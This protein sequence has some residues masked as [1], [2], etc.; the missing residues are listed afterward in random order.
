MQYN[1]VINGNC[2]IMMRQM[3]DEGINVD[4]ILTDPP[5]NLNKDFG[6]DSDRMELPDFLEVTKNRVG[7]CKQLLKACCGLGYTII[8][9]LYKPL[10]MKQVCII[11]E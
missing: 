8:S 10:C 7:M 3:I 2:D 4:L 11:G 1:T 5:Y 6:N 9:D